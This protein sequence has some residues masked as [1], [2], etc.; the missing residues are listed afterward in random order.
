MLIDLYAAGAASPVKKKKKPCSPS[1]NTAHMINK[2]GTHLPGCNEGAQ[3]LHF[4]SAEPAL[5]V[6]GAG[7]TPLPYRFSGRDAQHHKKICCPQ[8][9]EF[10]FAEG[11]DFVDDLNGTA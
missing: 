1:G 7:V 4:H 3:L 9:E 6:R 10:V 11:G 5:P 2:A 8:N